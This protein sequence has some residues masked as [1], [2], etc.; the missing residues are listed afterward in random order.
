M[1]GAGTAGMKR[2]RRAAS[3]AAGLAG[4]LLAGAGL[5]ASG[6]AGTGFVSPARAA[7]GL[8]TLP[9]PQPHPARPFAARLVP[10]RL[11]TAHLV[12]E[13]AVPGAVTV[14]VEFGDLPGWDKDDAAA[15]FRT[16]LISCRAL[17]TPPA[18]VGPASNTR[19]LPGLHQA[20]A[21]A[22]RLGTDRPSA[23]IARLFFEA[24]F[25]PFAIRPQASAQGFLTGYYEPEVDGSRTPDADHQV[26]VY[27]RPPDLIPG[28]GGP[29]S[30]KG[31]AFRQA[32]D[33]LVPYWDRA[34][35]EDGALSGKGLEVAWLKDPIDLFFMQIQGSA[36]VKLTDGSVLRLNYDGHNGQPYVPVGRLLIQRGQVP[37]EEM[38]MDRI[39]SFM[40][41]DPAAGKALRRENPS[42]V[43]FKA[44]PLAEGEGALGAQGWAS[45]PAAPSP[46]TGICTPTAHPSSSAPACRCAPR[47]RTHLSSG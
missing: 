28:G 2:P 43:F 14:P 19:L 38:S 21:A 31:P 42:Y 7:P 8:P 27:A 22:R 10:T 16:F 11:V 44:V 47:R 46:S 26:P 37:R 9:A 32:G 12:P 39:R 13:P 33:Q 18:E 1:R 25:R 36:R 41:A 35:I 6:L 24:N 40:E 23:L 29:Q 4:L 30:N 15:A 5:V 45:R 20:C 34:A 3:A 17:R